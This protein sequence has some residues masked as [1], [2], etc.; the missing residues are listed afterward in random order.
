[1]LADVSLSMAMASNE[2]LLVMRLRGR[3]V[4]SE[5]PKVLGRK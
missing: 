4:V 2:K 3:M 5:Q 1:M